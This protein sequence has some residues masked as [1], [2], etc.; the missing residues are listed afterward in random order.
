L[1]FV[2]TAIIILLV[3]TP[4][5]QPQGYA[6]EKLREWG[7]TASSRADDAVHRSG[8]T[9]AHR[10]ELSGTRMSAGTVVLLAASAAAGATVLGMLVAL[11]RPSVVAWLLPVVLP[12]LVLLAVRFVIEA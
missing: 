10:I 9:T 1:L 12:V 4:R 7:R 11:A 3:A 2:A 8:S 5:S 6:S